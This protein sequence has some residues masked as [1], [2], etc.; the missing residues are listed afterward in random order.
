LV[1]ENLSF[2]IESGFPICSIANYQFSM[3]NSQ[4]PSRMRFEALPRLCL[5]RASLSEL[6]FARKLRRFGPAHRERRPGN[7]FPNTCRRAVAET[8]IRRKARCMARPASGGRC[9]SSPGITYASGVG[10]NASR[11][12]GRSMSERNIKKKKRIWQK[13]Q[14]QQ[15]PRVWRKWW[16]E[17]LTRA[18]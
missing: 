10:R 6:I 7:E 15:T 18:S 5:N 14:N 9:S 4:W 11:C 16:I 3:T 1:I 13:S 12:S 17:F 8:R 2:A